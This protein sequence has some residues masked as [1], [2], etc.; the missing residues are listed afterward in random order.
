MIWNFN[1]ED[2]VDSQHVTES[3]TAKD[4][5]NRHYVTNITV[6]QQQP[7]DLRPVGE[8]NQINRL[9]YGMIDIE[10]LLNDWLGEAM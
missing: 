4:H 8:L 9:D 3:I 2:H 10:E 6:T 1:L 5:S 7:R